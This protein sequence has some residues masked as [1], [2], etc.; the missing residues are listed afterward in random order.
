MTP[1]AAI[2]AG[3]GVIGLACALQLQRA[4]IDTTLVGPGDVAAS[5]SWGSAGHLAVEQVEPLASRKAMRKGLRQIFDRTGALRAPVADFHHW[6]PFFLRL[7]AASAPAR[8]RFGTAAL[9]ACMVR[10]AFAWRELLADIGCPELLIES[11]HFVVWES[12][13]T[14]RAGRWGWSETK[15]GPARFRP[16]TREEVEHIESLLRRRI[17]G[18]I[19][20]EGTGQFTDPGILREKLERSVAEAG[21]RRKKALVSRIVADVATRAEIEM[22]DGC[23]IAADVLVV[24]AGVASGR[25]LAPLGIK[26]P[27]IAE[28]GYHIQA[29]A[30]AWPD[31][32]PPIVFEDRSI[33]ATNFTSGLRA[34]SFV[35]FARPERP[36]DPARWRVLENHVRELGV[37]FEGSVARWMGSRPTLPDY[38]PAI[39]RSTR[40]PFLYYAFGHQHLGLTLAAVTAEIVRDLVIGGAP[41]LDLAPFDVAR[42]G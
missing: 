36:P 4:G 14:A 15:T 38:L 1:K 3:D 6:L 33:I 18:A 35:E 41:L 16:A 11:G 22:G 8:L 13:E 25:L 2:V 5:A 9:S 32:M 37:P 10:A 19:R 31:D 21:V 42:F 7:A 26:A 23:R 40:I 12:Q 27:I 39:G 30:D 34:S 24:A 17:H 20:F 29:S 28:R